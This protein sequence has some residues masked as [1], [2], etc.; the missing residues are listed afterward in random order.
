MSIIFEALKK[1]TKE[2]GSV[3]AEIVKDTSHPLLKNSEAQTSRPD[4]LLRSCKQGHGLHLSRPTFIVV[5]M[6]LS[7][8]TLLSFIFR[9]DAIL[10]A[11]RPQPQIATPTSTTAPNLAAEGYASPHLIP[12]QGPAAVTIFKSKAPHLRLTL[13]GIVYGFSKPAAI[14][15]NKILEEGNSIKGAKVLKIYNDRVDLLNESSG[16]IFTLKVH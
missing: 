3:T 8:G 2:G 6:I 5:A 7:V 12:K 1:V 9:G 4:A 13:S 10:T 14:I 11:K 15:E 16:E